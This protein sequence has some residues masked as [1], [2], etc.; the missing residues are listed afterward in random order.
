MRS[1][2]WQHSAPR[3]RV[4]APGRTSSQVNRYTANNQYEPAVAV[5]RT[6]TSSSLDGLARTIEGNTASIAP[7]VQ[8]LPA[9]PQGASSRSTP[10]PP[11][12]QT[13]SGRRGGRQ[14]RL[15]G[16]LA[17]LRQDGLELRRLRPAIH[18][19]G[20]PLASEFQVNSYTA[21][22]QCAAHGR[23]RRRRRLRR[24]LAERSARTAALR[25]LRP[26]FRLAGARAGRRVPGQHLHHRATRA[27]P[28]VASDADGDFV[29]A[30]E[31]YSQDG[32]GDGIFARR[33]NSGG[34]RRSAAEF[35]VNTYTTDDQRMPAIA[36]D[37]DGDFVVAWKSHAP[38]R[39]RPRR[40][41]A[42]LQL[43]GAA[44]G[45]EFQVN[46]YTPGNQRRRRSL[47]RR[48]RLRRR[49]AELRP[50]RRRLRRLRP[51]LQPRRRPAAPS[52]RSTPH[53]G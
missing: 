32:D 17:E 24:R 14:W 25:R 35:Q 23:R 36:A 18:L 34:R 7:A 53:H 41:R 50:G 26:P 27:H 38:G 4:I 30:W 21:N 3:S 13:P 15:R 29:V 12:I 16:R 46:T 47:R 8:T 49:L 48:R 31:S 5:E 51:A 22:N 20:A 6:V 2:H 45:G 33:F 1:G 43:A 11:N 28:A 42:A 52:S 44:Q 19:P 10:T 39:R 9:L 37:A 40:L